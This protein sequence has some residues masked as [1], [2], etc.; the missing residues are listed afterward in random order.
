M[1]C[2]CRRAFTKKE[3]EFC[4]VWTKDHETCQKFSTENWNLQQPIT[5]VIAGLQNSKKHYGIRLMKV[6]RNKTLADLIKV[7]YNYIDNITKLIINE[8]LQVDQMYNAARTFLF[9][10]VILFR[11]AR[12]EQMKHNNGS[13]RCS[14]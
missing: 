10:S 3:W 9:T 13:K 1:K 4:T 12:Q 14:W 7:A 8:D 2:F 5:T 6:W 11:K